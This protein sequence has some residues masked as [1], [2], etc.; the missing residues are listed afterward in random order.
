MHGKYHFPTL[1]K[2]VDS[3]ARENRVSQEVY[4]KNIKDK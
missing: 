4:L 1:L 3:L 2:E